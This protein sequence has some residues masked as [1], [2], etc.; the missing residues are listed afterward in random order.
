MND[1]NYF[2]LDHKFPED[3]MKNLDSKI[4]IKE[5]EIVVGMC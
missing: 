3:V 5:A 4:N 2:F 1:K